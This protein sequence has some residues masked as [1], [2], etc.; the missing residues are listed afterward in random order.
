MLQK[1]NA[2]IEG[3]GL[4]LGGVA[5]GLLKAFADN[6]NF[7]ELPVGFTENDIQNALL[8]CP[9]ALYLKQVKLKSF[10]ILFFLSIL[11]GMARKSEFQ[12]VFTQN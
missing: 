9:A 11:N 5:K 6:G 3:A 2:L 8:N 1:G 12:A 4:D 10:K 7:G